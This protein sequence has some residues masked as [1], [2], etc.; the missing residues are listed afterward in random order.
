MVGLIFGLFVVPLLLVET[1]VA[2][3][4]PFAPWVIGNVLV[5]PL[6]VLASIAVHESGHAVV[7]RALGLRV[8]CIEIG[9]G[10]RMAKRRYRGLRVQLNAFPI[11]GLTLIAS[12]RRSGVRWRLWLATL[13]GPLATL[14]VTWTALAAGN[15][16]LRDVLWPSAAVAATP[17]VAPLLAFI[18]CWALVRNLLPLRVMGYRSDGLQLIRLPSCPDGELEVLRIIPAL[19]DA[20][21]AMEADELVTAERVLDA[22]FEI[23]PRSWL[24]RS[25]IA[26]V[27]IMAGRLVDARAQLCELMAEDPPSPDMGWLVRNNLAWTNFMIGDAALLAEADELSSAVLAQRRNTP[28]AMG[29]RGAILGW[30]GRH[31]EAIVMLEKAFVRTP[32]ASHRASLACCL[33]IS[34]AALA[35]SREA[36]FYRTDAERWLE[37]A[38]ALHARCPLLER[39][40]AA[41]A[42]AQAGGREAQ[43]AA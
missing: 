31:D 40:A 16:Q 12:D 39:A 26:V 33:A 35:I 21:D 11:L 28:S 14:A 32:T 4:Q 27:R 19:I 41:V 18:N 42:G 20:A 17:A 30:L 34:F 25:D 9:I 36:L 3:G 23:A 15:L 8:L 10:R 37:R 13:A 7:A 24:L 29:T 2:R 43:S 38:R 1:A 22:A 6:L 5:Y